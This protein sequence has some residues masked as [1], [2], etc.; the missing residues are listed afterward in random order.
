[1]SSNGSTWD[2]IGTEGFAISPRMDGSE[3]Y[4][5]EL[6]RQERSSDRYDTEFVEGAD[7]HLRAVVLA[8]RARPADFAGALA[9]LME[10]AVHQGFA[11]T[12]DGWV[13]NE[14]GDYVRAEG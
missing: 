10:E 9:N 7:G 2:Q 4:G 1:M 12:P 8:V 5:W 3:Q 13:R 11:A 14:H 6:W